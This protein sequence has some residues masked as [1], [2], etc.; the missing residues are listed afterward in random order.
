[1]CSA[2]AKSRVLVV[3][4]DPTALLIC[5]THLHFAGYEVVLASSVGNARNLLDQWGYDSF[6]AVFTDFRMPVED[7]LVLLR[8]IVERDSSLAV[9]VMTAES[10]KELIMSSLQQGAHNFIEK[11]LTKAVLLEAAHKGAGATL[12]QRNLRAD[13]GAARAVGSSQRF[14]LGRETEVC[15]DRLSIRFYPYQ[16]AGGDFVATFQLDEHRFVVIVSDMSGHDLNAAYHS[17]YLQGLARGL[18]LGGADLPSVFAR[19]NRMLLED[20]NAHDQ[21]VLSLAACAICVDQREGLVTMLNCGLPNPLVSDSSGGISGDAVPG[22]SPLG[23]FDDLPEVTR[24]ALGEGLLHF[25]SDGLSDL[26]DHYGVSPLSLVCRL[27]DDPESARALIEPSGDDIVVGRINLAEDVRQSVCIP[28]F[29]ETYSSG[30]EVRI[31]QIQSYVERSMRM[32]LPE[33]SADKLID[34]LLCLREGLLNAFEHGCSGESAGIVRLQVSLDKVSECLRLRITDN[35][36]GHD[37][38]L[39]NYEPAAADDLLT[40]HRG[41]IMMKN[42][43]SNLCISERGTRLDMDITLITS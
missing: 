7:G 5:K 8:H 25:W 34:T 24:H 1:M 40:E 36:A 14:L 22:A 9:I 43:S 10:E 6:A 26:A 15:N 3:D 2:P 41:L 33:M 30:D 42:L 32:A 35:G 37:F 38:D 13:A 11:P 12:Q 31:D 20:W 4:D 19:I 17:V 27:Q 18:L 39:E 23:W 29:V 16:V 21:I 28:L